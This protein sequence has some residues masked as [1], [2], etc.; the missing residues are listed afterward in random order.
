[1]FDEEK[2]AMEIVPGEYTIRVG[3]S[4]NELPLQQAL[5]LK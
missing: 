3:G 1:V 5:T 2:D 4:S